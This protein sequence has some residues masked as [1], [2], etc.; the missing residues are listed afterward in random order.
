MTSHYGPV[1]TAYLVGV[2]ARVAVWARLGRIDCD[3]P[4]WLSRWE[5]QVPTGRAS[6]L[7]IDG[8]GE[9]SADLSHA[10]A[11]QAT[12]SLGQ[13]SHRHAFD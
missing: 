9:C 12:Q 8:N 3:P 13:K 7:A 10:Q 6:V 1:T 2:M 5:L 4:R 11:A